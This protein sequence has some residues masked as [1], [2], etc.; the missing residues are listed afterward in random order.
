MPVNKW[1]VDES[2]AVHPD[3]KSHTGGLLIL[4][5]GAIACYSVKQK[6]CTRSSTEAEL[7]GVDD[8]IGQ[9]LWTSQFLHAQKCFDFTL[10]LVAKF[11]V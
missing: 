7:V 6:L 10:T 4:G 1:W 11:Q 5:K 3:C 8:M 9:V 2:Y